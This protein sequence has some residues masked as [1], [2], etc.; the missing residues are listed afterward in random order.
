MRPFREREVVG[1]HD[2][3]RLGVAVELFQH[4]DD[5]P[6][7]FLVEISGRLVGEQDLR[8][9]GE[10]SCQSYSLLFSTGELSRKVVEPVT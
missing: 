7:R 9:I 3:R 6:A 5:R 4:L 10:G 1:H 2:Q 8:A